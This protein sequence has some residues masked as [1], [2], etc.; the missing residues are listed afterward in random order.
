MAVEALEGQFGYTIHRTLSYPERAERGT[1][2]EMKEEDVAAAMSFEFNEPVFIDDW[3]LP[4]GAYGDSS[5][6]T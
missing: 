4:A 2:Y 6:P 3:T 5:G 1:P